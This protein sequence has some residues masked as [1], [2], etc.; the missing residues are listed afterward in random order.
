MISLII[1][2]YQLWN[3]YFAILPLNIESLSIYF[4][5]VVNVPVKILNLDEYTEEE[6]EDLVI[7]ISNRLKQLWQT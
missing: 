4:C 5:H 7:I 1:K 2:V 6:Q 3:N